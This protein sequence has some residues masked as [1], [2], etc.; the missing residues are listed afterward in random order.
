[1]TEAQDAKPSGEVVDD[2]AW[3]VDGAQPSPSSSAEGLGDTVVKM[4]KVAAGKASPRP[5]MGR[6]RTGTQAKQD[7]PKQDGPR[8][9]I[10]KPV[11]QTRTDD[12]MAPFDK[13]ATPGSPAAVP[14]SAPSPRPP[15]ATQPM[16]PVPS[17]A[18]PRPAAGGVLPP[19][20]TPGAVPVASVVGRPVAPAPRP[21]GAPAAAARRTRKAR[22]RVARVDPWSVMKT[23]FLFSIA[24]GVMA[25][26]ATYLLWQILLASGLFAAINDAIITIISSPNNTEGWRIE[27]Y[28]S[29]NKVLGVTALLAVINV[30]ITT[31]LGTL[32]A[33]LYNL[34]AN[35]LGGLEL[36]L[37][38]D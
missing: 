33:F 5:T 28:L 35:I 36:T 34:S 10:P 23:V 17:M 27:D 32:G 15:T 14:A 13:P 19:T 26:V 21:A 18:M 4:P 25:W 11:R 3:Q 2:A 8:P 37:A 29:A 30:V 1:M 7:A 6:G 20:A 31:A 9:S 38:E 12:L 24:F 22:L 16:P